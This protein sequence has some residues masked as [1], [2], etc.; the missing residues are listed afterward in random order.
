MNTSFYTE[1]QIFVNRICLRYLKNKE[2]ADDLT[3]EI[4]LKLMDRLC[5]FN[6]QCQLKTWVYRAAVNQCLDYLRWK[7]RQALLMEDAAQAWRDGYRE[8]DPM[9][10]YCTDRFVEK[11]IRGLEPEEKSLL[12]LHLEEGLTH[13][14]IATQAG[15]S[16]VAITKRLSRVEERLQSIRQRL[17]ERYFTLPLA[18]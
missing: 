12:E 5:E 13:Q 4:L 3:Q 15:V 6:G 8:E 16:R 2:D 11:V 7:K 9:E 1:H 14:Q 17:E 10:D 18:A